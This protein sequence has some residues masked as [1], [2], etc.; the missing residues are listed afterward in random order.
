MRL[1]DDQLVGFAFIFGMVATPFVMPWIEGMARRVKRK[2][3]PAPPVE[4][5]Y[6]VNDYLKST[7]REDAERN[8]R[9][10]LDC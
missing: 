5:V 6:N 8:R 1:S 10:P 3:K 9:F 2:R 4:R 7:T